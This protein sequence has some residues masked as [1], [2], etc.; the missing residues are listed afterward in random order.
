MIGP[1]LPLSSDRRQGG[2]A[3]MIVKSPDERRPLRGNGAMPTP[4]SRLTRSLQIG[5]VP[6]HSTVATNV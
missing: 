5:N 3:H 2:I 1:A 6:W 4:D